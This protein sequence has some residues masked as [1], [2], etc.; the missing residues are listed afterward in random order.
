MTYVFASKRSLSTLSTFFM[1][2]SLGNVMQARMVLPCMPRR[3]Q[4]AAGY[5]C[6]S[7]DFKTD[8]VTL[9]FDASHD[10][11]NLCMRLSPRRAQS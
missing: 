6:D 9:L 10:H 11:S 8:G 7:Q 3:D 4:V 1:V 5:E 2:V